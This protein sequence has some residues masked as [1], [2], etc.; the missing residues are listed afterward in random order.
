M[1]LLEL[2][3]LF[4]ILK[5]YLA[6]LRTAP[7]YLEKAAKLTLSGFVAFDINGDLQTRI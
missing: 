7:P 6:I 3:S 4:Y 2:S 5:R 1:D